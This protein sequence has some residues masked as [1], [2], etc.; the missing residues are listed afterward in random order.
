MVAVKKEMDSFLAFGSILYYYSN[1]KANSL[2]IT[3]TVF[4]LLLIPLTVVLGAFI[5]VGMGKSAT[6]IIYIR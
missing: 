4:F 3:S 1:S 2:Q 5:V 6:N